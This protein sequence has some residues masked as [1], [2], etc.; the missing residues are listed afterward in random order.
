MHDIE[1][2]AASEP[3]PEATVTSH[4]GF[5]VR[6]ATEYR[7]RGLAFEDLCH[8][9]NVGL[10]MAA[11]LYDPKR[12]AKFTSYAVYWI[13]KS[14]LTAIDRHSTILHVPQHQL[15]RA[16]YLAL[17]ESRLRAT[18]GREQY[19]ANVATDLGLSA[20]AAR[21]LRAVT[22]APVSLDAPRPSG[23]GTHKDTLLDNATADPEEALLLKDTM[24]RVRQAVARL[25]ETP[26]RV[27]E[28]RYGI[29]DGEG[30]TLQDVAL[31]LGVTR[32]R[33]RQIEAQA[34]TLLKKRL[35][36]RSFP[37][38]SHFAHHRLSI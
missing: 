21:A 22:T 8:E 10:L 12:G 16:R 4:L 35:G 13:R 33:V 11:R 14:M 24:D 32:E 25:E 23:D 5:V 29:P 9:G 36:M 6:I 28:H 2:I 3:D 19:P 34:L 15:R 26:R 7:H 1:A 18:L 38:P 20:S 30:A 31:S 17:E 37:L 27:I